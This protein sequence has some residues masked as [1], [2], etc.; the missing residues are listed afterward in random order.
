MSKIRALCIFCGANSGRDAKLEDFASAFGSACAARDIDLIF[1]GGG[2]GLMGAMA[3]A[4]LAKGGH[5][6]GIIPRSLLESENTPTGL[7]E[8]VV[9]DSMHTRKQ[10]MFQR[11]DGFV[12]LPGGFGTL[13]ET[14][15]I[16]TWRQLGLHDKPII[17]ANYRG[18]WDLL[19][20]LLDH[21]T[22]CG[23]AHTDVLNLF[24]VTDSIDGIFDRLKTGTV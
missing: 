4:A 6:T 21:I 3:N 24:E 8:L 5:V 1:G 18:F 2:D 16:I 15:E 22:E 17:L 11:A 14:I 13:E 12:S 7:T 9:V 19:V 23:F 20:S 10:Q